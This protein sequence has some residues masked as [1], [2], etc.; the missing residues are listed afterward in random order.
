MAMKKTLLWVVLLASCGLSAKAQL[1]IDIQFGGSSY[2]S[3]VSDIQT[4]PGVVGTA[5]DYWNDISFSSTVYGSL[6]TSLQNVG[7]SSSGVSLK[8]TPNN[9]TIDEYSGGPG[10]S[11]LP[12]TALSN[13]YE[14]FLNSDSYGYPYTTA[15]SD[16]K[17]SG[18]TSGST[19]SLYIYSAP[20]RDRESGWSLNGATAV[21]VGFNSGATTLEA[22]N[23]YIVLTGTADSGGNL[24]LV[25]SQL[26]GYEMDVNGFQLQEQVVPEPSVYALL[27][28]GLLTLVIVQRKR[29]RVA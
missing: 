12:S 6:T 7:N 29:A 21:Q 14:G 22:P 19:Y 27:I 13:L 28:G 16:F 24:D 2:N 5:G 4:G 17:F 25:A 1:L 3:N 10:S 18:L 23:N 8:I 20:N 11:T 26:S 15:G 9:G